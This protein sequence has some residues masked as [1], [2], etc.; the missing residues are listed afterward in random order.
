MKK[1]GGGT[2]R[3]KGN[4]LIYKLNGKKKNTFTVTASKSI[5]FVP[6]IKKANGPPF[7]E[8]KKDGEA[9]FFLSKKSSRRGPNPREGS[10]P[11]PSPPPQLLQNTPTPAK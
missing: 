7:L 2:K 11:P 1:K 10:P 5:A 3:K 8:E 9:L 6:E 4:C